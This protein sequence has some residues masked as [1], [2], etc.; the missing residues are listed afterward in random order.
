MAKVD[1]FEDLH[2]WQAARAMTKLVYG[3]CETGKLAKDFETR[4]QMKGAALSAMSNIAEGFGRGSDREFLRFL[5]ISQSSSI[6]VKSISY[7]LEDSHYLP[8]ELIIRIKESAEK[9][10]GLTLGLM[11]YLRR[12]K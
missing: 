11:K 9:A 8:E 12:K 7:A 6:E 5:N 4:A 10:K 2:C 3:A 1:R